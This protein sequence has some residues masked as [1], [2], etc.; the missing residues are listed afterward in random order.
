[1][2]KRKDHH[3]MII[4]KRYTS[5]R[6]TPPYDAVVIGSGIGGMTTAAILSRLGNKV[7]VLEQ[8]YT[9]GG[10]T[11]T[12]T[13][14]GY[15]FDVGLH[16]VGEMGNQSSPLKRIFD[17]IT[18]KQLKWHRTTDVYDRFFFKDDMYEFVA[19]K[20]RFQKRMIRYFPYEKK[21]ITQYLGLLNEINM[22]TPPYFMEKAMPTWVAPFLNTFM[23]PLAAKYFEQTTKT[24]LNHLTSNQQLI[25]VLTGQMGTY[26]LPPSKASFGIHALV[27]HHFLDGA[28]FPI[29]GSSR[30][31]ETI[32]P[33]IEKSGGA[34]L[35]RA[36][37][38]QILIRNGRVCGVKLENG[39]EIESKNVVSSIG[40]MNTFGSLISKEF[41]QPDMDQALKKLSPSCGHIC[42]FIGLNESAE[43]LGLKQTNIW[44]Y[45]DYDHDNNYARSL[46]DGPDFIPGAF[47][48]FPSTKDP[49]WNSRYPGKSTIQ[50]ISFAP[51]DWFKKWENTG[52]KKRGDD[53]EALKQQ[54]TENL[55]D[56]LY[57]HVPKVKNKIDYMSLSTP[58][59]TRH[60]CNYQ[61]GEIYGLEHTPERFQ[62]RALRAST[63]IKG[64]YLSGQDVVA[65]GIAG[66]TITGAM[67]AAAM[68]GPLFKDQ[69]LRKILGY[70]S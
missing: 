3:Q 61:Q 14:K 11:H 31:A 58:L 40:V 45:P 64:L 20:S 24:V 35:T 48:S 12:F 18:H 34:M 13:H 25:S 30:I 10:F 54:L 28:Y 33:V 62:Q 39:D 2:P 32:E 27:A 21:A 51:Y 38:D 56:I 44:V 23:R 46:S 49:E 26:G 22:L 8:H 68:T 6:I 7:L 9:A 37:V 50:I 36:K 1:M 17:F 57:Q 42:L 67:T 15:E 65:C 52:W 16:Y 5:E 53:Y 59:T 70:P 63:S 69:I 29:G 41:E 55:L 19:G 66:A 43:S 47:I 4:G 60:F